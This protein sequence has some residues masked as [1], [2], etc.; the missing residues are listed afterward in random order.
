M[1][2]DELYYTSQLDFIE[3]GAHTHAHA[4]LGEAT[5]EQAHREM[6]ACKQE[7]EV[8]IGKPVLSF[9][10]P[11]GRYSPPCP[12]A[13]EAAGYTSAAT[14]GLQ[15]GW[16]PYE[17]RRELIAPGDLPLRFGLKA[18]GLYRPLVSSPPARWRRRLRAAR[19]R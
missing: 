2:R 14:C 12:A 9:A 11:Y 10:Y 19:A 16:T 7:L 18:R 3:I 1:D 5:L 6:V 15:G 8:L 13:A 4:D 17:L